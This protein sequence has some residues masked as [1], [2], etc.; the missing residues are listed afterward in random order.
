MSSSP[1]IFYKKGGEL[2]NAYYDLCRIYLIITRFCISLTKI[3]HIHV[4]TMV[5]YRWTTGYVGNRYVRPGDKTVMYT[6][7]LVVPRKTICAHNREIRKVLSLKNIL[8][9]ATYWW[10]WY[11]KCWLDLDALAMSRG[12]ELPSVS[13][14]GNREY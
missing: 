14:L 4:G 6:V 1:F 13:I 5:R 12:N 11:K 9:D 8:H 7:H 2:K 3:R 10:S